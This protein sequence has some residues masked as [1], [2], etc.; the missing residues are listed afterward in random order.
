MDKIDCSLLGTMLILGP[1][2]PRPFLY[3]FVVSFWFTMTK[4]NYW[5]SVLGQTKKLWRDKT[6]WVLMKN[7]TNRTKKKSMKI[8][9]FGS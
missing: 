3:L 2:I 7:N 8:D 1:M 4:N 6:I 9:V 5:N